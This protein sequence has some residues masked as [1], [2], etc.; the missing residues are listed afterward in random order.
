ME[1]ALTVIICSRG[2]TGLMA[3]QNEAIF[4]ILIV[5]DDPAFVYLLRQAFQDLSRACELHWV[6]D[7]EEA[8]DFLHRRNSHTN[9]TAPHLILMDINMPRIN[10]LQAVQAIKADPAHSVLPVIVLSTGARPS[11]VRKIYRSHANA[12]VQKPADFRGFG[13]LLKAIEAF[14]MDFA[15]LPSAQDS[16]RLAVSDKGLPIASRT[17][18]V[19]SQAMS[20]DESAAVAGASSGGLHCEE[21]QRLMEDF[22]DAVKELLALHEQQF[23]AIVQGDPECN[24]FDLLI[25]MANEKKQEAKY[26]YLR[27]VESHGYSNFDAITNASGA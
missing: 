12:Y 20:M 15:V 25:H 19:R 6:K 5:D 11:E 7:G 9:A 3:R 21:H 23:Q 16:E 8:L 1:S 24:R 14:W 13:D 2:S 4:Q 22:A 17:S 26:A 18:E 27:H 10:G